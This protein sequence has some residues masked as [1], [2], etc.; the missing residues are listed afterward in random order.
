[1]DWITKKVKDEVETMMKRQEQAKQAIPV[2]FHEFIVYL[3]QNKQIGQLPQGQSL[4]QEARKH[5]AYDKDGMVFVPL[6]TP[7]FTVDG[8]VA[9]ARAEHR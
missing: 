3:R 6:D 8:R 1:M 9:W 7:Y 4:S 2:Q 5:G